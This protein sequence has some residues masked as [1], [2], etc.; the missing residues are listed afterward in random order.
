M[1]YALDSH[2]DDICKFSDDGKFLDRF[3]SGANSPNA[4]A[5]DPNGRLFISDTSSI[6]VL[7]P[8]GQVIKSL[9]SYQAFGLVFNQQGELLVA[10]RPHVLKHK[11][12]F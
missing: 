5:F 2:N 9:P 7:D 8:G 10:A 3:P 11:M 12:N 6:K 1:I 4:L